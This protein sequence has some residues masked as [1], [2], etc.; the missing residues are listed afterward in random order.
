MTPS[1]PPRQQTSPDVDRNWQMTVVVVDD[2]ILAA[3]ENITGTRLLRVSRAAL[4]T[5]HGLFPSPE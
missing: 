5:I 4:H 3:V 1:A 2:Y